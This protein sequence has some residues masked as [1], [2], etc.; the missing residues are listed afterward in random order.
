MEEQKEKKVKKTNLVNPKFSRVKRGYLSPAEHNRVA[1]LNYEKYGLYLEQKRKQYDNHFRSSA[2]GVN[3]P[4]K[5]TNLIYIDLLKLVYMIN[6]TIEM[7][8]LSPEKK[9]LITVV[10]GVLFS[11]NGLSKSDLKLACGKINQNTITQTITE[12]KKKGYLYVIGFTPQYVYI[13]EKGMRFYISHV[14]FPMMRKGDKYDF[15][16]KLSNFVV[17]N[18]EIAKFKQ[19]I[20]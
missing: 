16:I 2:T 20:S 14:L 11:R 1:Q 12:A 4:H 18:E 15:R 6:K 19:I 3:K 8:F 9:P 7:L 5:T 13:T 17:H 10:L